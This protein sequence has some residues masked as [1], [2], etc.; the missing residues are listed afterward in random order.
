M[1]G[2]LSLDNIIINSDGVH[3]I[4][5]EHYVADAA[6][7][8]FDALYLLFESLYFGMYLGRHQRH[9]PTGMEIQIVCEHIKTIN[10]HH[11][12]QSDMLKA[13]LQFVKEFVLANHHLWGEQLALFQMKLPII[14]FSSD[15]IAVIDEMISSGMA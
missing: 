15:Q 11:Q 2:D 5:W 7:W 10:D 1:H 14:A 4:D 13:P 6:P 8:G 12:L 3:I 9:K